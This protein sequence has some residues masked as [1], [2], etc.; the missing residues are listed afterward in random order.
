MSAEGL[1]AVAALALSLVIG[2]ATILSERRSSIRSLREACQIAEASPHSAALN[3][4]ALGNFLIVVMGD[5]DRGLAA[6]DAA[7]DASRAALDLD[8]DA[9]RWAMANMLM[10]RANSLGW[11]SDAV[12]RQAPFAE[13]LAIADEME[14]PLPREMLRRNLLAARDGAAPWPPDGSGPGAATVGTDPPG[15]PGSPTAAPP[16]LA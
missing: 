3:Y 13:A 1:V 6:D 12:G 9:G 2:V 7:I 5:L 10:H 15:S 16:G 11:A 14:N 8:T 4:S